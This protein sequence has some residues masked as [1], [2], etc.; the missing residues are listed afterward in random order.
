MWFGFSSLQIIIKSGAFE[1][2]IRFSSLWI[3]SFGAFARI[4]PKNEPLLWQL[5]FVSM[6][7]WYWKSLDLSTH[8][9]N[10]D[11]CR[12]GKSIK[13]QDRES[14]FWIYLSLAGT[15]SNSRFNAVVSATMFKQEAR[16]SVTA[17]IRS[18]SVTNQSM[19]P[20]NNAISDRKRD[21]TQ[22]QINKDKIGQ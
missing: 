7:Y 4:V 19:Q 1:S 11:L 22:N 18:T 6:A 21:K 5:C 10:R 8:M 20:I 15:H 2:T 3:F 14:I 17:Q 13:R 12:I 16:A 9:R